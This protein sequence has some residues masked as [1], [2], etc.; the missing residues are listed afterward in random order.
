MSLALK[1]V[2]SPLLVAQARATRRRALVL[3]EAEGPREGRLGPRE[4]R[5]VRV[6]IAGDSS[7]AGVGVT[8]QRDAVAG[9]LVAALQNRL[10]RPVEWILR[11]RSGLTTVQLHAL[12]QAEPPSAVDVAV[13]VTGVNDVIDQVPSA[14]AVQHRA[15]IADWLLDRG[16]ARHVV[17]APLPPIGRFP[18]LPQPL[19]LTV[20]RETPQYHGPLRLL[21][22][23]QRIEAGWWDEEGKG[24]ALRDYFIARSETVG[25]V[26][27]YR[28]RPASPSDSEAQARWYLQ[29]LYA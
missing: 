3:P 5:A 23:P 4:G 18:L 26:W 8:H 14:R 16:L 17:F 11:A 12:L 28:E 15:A 25:L 29:G 1:L 9:H 24:L 21:T 19:R 6:L 27:I 2:L 22:R 20:Q 10:R 7:A 13:V